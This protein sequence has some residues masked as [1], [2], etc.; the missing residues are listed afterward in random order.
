LNATNP[1]IYAWLVKSGVMIRMKTLGFIG[2]GDWA[3]YTIK[4]LDRED[5][6]NQFYSA[7]I[8]V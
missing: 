7:K 6:T 3:E 5:F 8:I 4:G 2:V 1:S